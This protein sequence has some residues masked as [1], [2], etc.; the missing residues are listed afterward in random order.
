MADAFADLCLAWLALEV[1][2]PTLGEVVSRE[3]IEQLPDLVVAHGIHARAYLDQS[4]PIASVW[5]RARS[6]VPNS[7][8]SLFLAARYKASQQELAGAA[9]DLATLLD[10]HPQHHQLRFDLACWLKEDSQIDEAIRHLSQ[11]VH[12]DHSYKI[13]AAND[14]AYLLAQHRPD[15]LDQAFELAHSSLEVWPHMMALSDTVGWIE[16]LRGNHLDAL[17]HLN[18]AVLSLTSVPEV[19]FHLGAV[20]LELGDRTWARYHFEQAA[21]SSEDLPEVSQAKAALKK[22]NHPVRKAG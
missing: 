4:K 10:R 18:R 5:E 6:Q 13:F 21:N 7:D 9:A 8:L 1:D 2:L 22:W 11:L 19:H 3:V 15:Q 20:Y 12:S 14:L 16:H 17:R